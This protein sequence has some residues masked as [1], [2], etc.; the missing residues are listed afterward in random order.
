VQQVVSDR[1]LRLCDTST[2]EEIRRF[3]KGLAGSRGPQSVSPDGRRVLMRSDRS[4]WLMDVDT[5]KELHRF[6]GHTAGVAS[7]VFLPDGKFALTSS[8]DNTMRLWR[9]PDL[10]PKKDKP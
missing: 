9:L 4:V 7:A 6:D 5:G 10:P 1:A 3:E 8:L 2:G